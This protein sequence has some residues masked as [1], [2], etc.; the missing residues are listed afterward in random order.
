MGSPEIWS[1]IA[2]YVEVLPPIGNIVLESTPP[3]F[4]KTRFTGEAMTSAVATTTR[5]VPA[6]APNPTSEP[7]PTKEGALVEEKVLEGS[8]SS[9]EEV[10]AKVSTSPKGGVSPTSAWT[11]E[12]PF[13]TLP[14]IIS[15]NDLFAALP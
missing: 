15:S 7:V 10:S 8:S 9:A 2:P 14:P 12:A 3:P 6:K 1:D 5:D 4:T 11:E 13:I